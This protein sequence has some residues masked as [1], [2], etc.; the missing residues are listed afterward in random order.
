MIPAVRVAVCSPH[1]GVR[2]VPVSD[3]MVAQPDAPF[4][5]VDDAVRDVLA[6][7]RPRPGQREA[8]DALVAGRDVLAV[9]PTGWGKSAVYQIAGLCRAGATVVVSP[10]IALQR[11]QVARLES[12]E[13]APAGVAN[14][15][16]PERQVSEAFERFQHGD[17]E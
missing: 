8:V 11:D 1:R 7:A 5:N 12:D 14:S 10:L 4:A 17:L 16:L 6:D 15:M 9:L 13:V 2:V 3:S